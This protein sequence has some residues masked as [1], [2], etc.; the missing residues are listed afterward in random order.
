[1]SITIIDTNNR[2]KESSPAGTVRQIV[3]SDDRAKDLRAAIHD[4]GPGKCQGQFVP[5]VGSAGELFSGGG[6]V[7]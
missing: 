7:I 3:T 5:S 2:P 4:I 1:M 6:C